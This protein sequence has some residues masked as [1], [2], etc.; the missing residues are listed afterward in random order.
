MKTK[1]NDPEKIALVNHLAREAF[2]QQQYEFDETLPDL[3]MEPG[4]TDT[5]EEKNEISHSSLPK[6]R[7]K[8]TQS[9]LKTLYDIYE[10]RKEL[11]KQADRWIKLVALHTDEEHHIGSREYLDLLFFLFVFKEA[12]QTSKKHGNYVEELSDLIYS[13]YGRKQLIQKVEQW[14]RF[15]A[16]CTKKDHH[17]GGTEYMNLLNFFF[18]LK[19]QLQNSHPHPHSHSNS[20]SNSNSTHPLYASAISKNPNED[21]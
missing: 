20:N 4:F 19:E 7:I 14:T 6:K 1:T 15:V 12:F 9:L 18:V 3:L 11:V 2:I 8:L 21:L 17:T 13:L 10:S 16:L 5:C